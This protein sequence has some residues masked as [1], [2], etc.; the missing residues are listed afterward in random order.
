MSF[1]IILPAV[2]STSSATNFCSATVALATQDHPPDL[3]VVTRHLQHFVSSRTKMDTSANAELGLCT[4][5]HKT[6]G[7]ANAYLGLRHKNWQLFLHNPGFKI[8]L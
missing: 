6:D 5:E 7:T 2:L 8:L 1:Q 4:A 3:Q